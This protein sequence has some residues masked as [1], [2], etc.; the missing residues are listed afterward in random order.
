M[1]IQIIRCN[2]SIRHRRP[3]YPPRTEGRG[4]I[5]FALTL[6]HSLTIW[7]DDAADPLRSGILI[8]SLYRTQDSRRSEELVQLDHIYFEN[9]STVELQAA[10][11]KS[12]QILIDMGK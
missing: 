7:H 10:V 2:Y 4:L 8:S 11:P 6:T 9:R 3:I 5:H 12:Q 1:S